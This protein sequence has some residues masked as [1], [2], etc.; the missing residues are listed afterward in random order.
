MTQVYSREMFKKRHNGRT[1]TVC[2][3][4]HYIGC[5]VVELGTSCKTIF[6]NEKG[7]HLGVCGCLGDHTINSHQQVMNKR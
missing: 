2:A 7:E 3:P 6:T 4:C 1:V 5:E